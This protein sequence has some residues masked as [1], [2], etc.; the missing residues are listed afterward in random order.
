MGGRNL[1]V[2]MGGGD[3]GTTTLLGDYD[4]ARASWFLA[5]IG[6]CWYIDNKRIQLEEIF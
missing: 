2:S 5:S 4:P 1:P 3:E 6:R